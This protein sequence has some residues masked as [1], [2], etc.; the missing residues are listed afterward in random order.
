MLQ[1]KGLSNGFWDEAIKTVVYLK[2]RSP[3]KF[4]GFKTP[5]EALYGFKP[6]VSHLR[7]FGSKYF[8]HIPK[9]DRKKLDPKAMKCIFVGY[10]TEFKEL[11]YLIL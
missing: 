2:N 4:L 9:V 1:G 6:V 3:T 7:V 8:S 5:F 11:S 10:G